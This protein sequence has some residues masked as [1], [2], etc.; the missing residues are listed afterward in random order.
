MLL[1]RLLCLHCVLELRSE[2]QSSC[3]THSSAVA[4]EVV[5][6][7]T[8]TSMG[9]TKENGNSAANGPAT[10]A[11]AG[12]ERPLTSKCNGASSKE[13]APPVLYYGIALG[14]GTTTCDDDELPLVFAD[15]TL[16]LR[17][18]KKYRGA[19]F[20]TFSSR[21]EAAQFS[22]Q[23]AAV[24]VETSEVPAVLMG[25]RS[26]P[27]RGPK[28]QDLVLFRK[29]IEAG[30]AAAF[31]QTVWSNP[32][33]LVS[34]GDTPTI[35]QEGFRYNALHVASMK[36]Q[37]ILV[38]LILETLQDLRLL[39]LLYTDDAPDVRL[40]RM[41]YILDLYL[42]TPDKGRCETPLHF[43]CKFGHIG[44][45]ELLLAQPLCDRNA[46]NKFGQTARQMICERKTDAG[47][48]V[49]KRMDNLFEDHFIVPII[50]S[51]DNS[52]PALVGEPFSPEAPPMGIRFMLE[53]TS[54][55]G[56]SLGTTSPGDRGAQVSFAALSPILESRSPGSVDMSP[57]PTVRNARDTPMSIVAAA[58]PMSPTEA[59]TMYHQYKTRLGSC[60]SLI[61]T[62]M[63]PSASGPS[64]SVKDVSPVHLRRADSEKGLECV[65]RSIARDLHVP[66]T[67][68]WPFLGCWC[69]LATPEGLEKLENHLRARRLQVLTEW[70]TRERNSPS[71]VSEEGG[72]HSPLSQL[73]RALDGLDLESPR[74]S[75]RHPSPPRFSKTR[76]MEGKANPAFAGRGH[77]NGD[78]ESRSESADDSDLPMA[79]QRLSRVLYDWAL[80]H[81]EGPGPEADLSSQL[82]DQV[83]QELDQ[84]EQAQGP[85]QLSRLHPELA[86]QVWA[87][88]RL[89]LVSHERL[90]LCRG[91]RSQLSRWSLV[92]SPSSTD[93]ENDDGTRADDWRC[94]KPSKRR[95]GRVL[96]R[97]LQCVLQCLFT[98]IDSDEDSGPARCCCTWSR[99]VAARKASH[100]DRTSSTDG[101]EDRFF[102]PP[103]SPCSSSDSCSQAG[104]P[105]E[106]PTVFLQGSQP[107]K[108][109]MDVVRALE[110]YLL[111]HEVP[112]PEV[113][114]CTHQWLQLVLSHP[115]E[116]MSSWPSPYAARYRSR[117]NLGL[118]TNSPQT[119]SIGGASPTLDRTPL[120]DGP[121]AMR[122]KLLWNTSLGRLG[123]L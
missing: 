109:D 94:R 82:V 69:N 108:V 16:A 103:T 110:P 3:S 97:H 65:G 25:E 80:S 11:F 68:Y 114:P 18:V 42:N 44:A 122:P 118:P 17:C 26:S 89:S 53:G 15:R 76:N 46:L 95:H 60:H 39:E 35:V 48:Q 24:P 91:L 111:E 117:H 120:R 83:L 32:R 85:S 67:E 34:G 78:T 29:M 8:M 33:Y 28:S 59:Q 66:W 31:Q 12:S 61:Q 2:L 57:F 22:M 121:K 40:R 36:G 102:T 58:G 1:G 90:G 84:L 86:K 81:D 88:L 119:T 104:T 71:P 54:P 52:V 64:L 112:D 113:Y 100:P 62:G 10:A 107:S 41:A 7:A 56:T 38:Q 30:N 98:L 63:S 73:C 72:S 19:R 14:A 75:A 27:Y 116:T 79:A 13:A 99:L 21:E 5:R 43:A 50:R 47:A 77:A 105:E 49:K 74:Q 123:P 20:K 23:P 6:D 101:D 87:S 96:R 92:P 9:M 115:A 106:G 93:D 37:S 4:A 55:A 70:R 51:E 45:V